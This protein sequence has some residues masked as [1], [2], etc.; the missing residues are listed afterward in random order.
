MKFPY[1]KFPLT[2]RSAYFGTSLLRP[3][4]PVQIQFA[5]RDI[6]YLALVDSGADFNIFHA[7]IG[8]AIGI[9]I[10]QGEEIDFGGIQSRAGAKGFFHEV[11][12]VIG[13]HAYETRVAFSW[14]IA[15]HGHG[16]FGQKGFFDVFK[17][18]FDYAKK[19]IE[20][21]PRT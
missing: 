15:E 18:T 1:L 5:H 13:G 3:I 14:D 12:L 4:I 7:E 19:V 17:V 6:D 20:M 2:E 21:K 16:V 10:E 11:T 9:E 8:Q